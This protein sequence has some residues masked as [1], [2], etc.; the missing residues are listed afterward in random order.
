M[1]VRVASSTALGSLNLPENSRPA[2][3]KTFLIHSCG[4]P[5][6]IA[7]RRGERR[8]TTGSSRLACPGAGCTAGCSEVMVP[9][10]RWRGTNTRRER[11]APLRVDQD[12]RIEHASRIQLSLDGTQAGGE[13]RRSL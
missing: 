13:R 7:A 11:V 1:K 6:L 10:R 9:M 2:K 8:G 4:R 12:A 5:V 3:T